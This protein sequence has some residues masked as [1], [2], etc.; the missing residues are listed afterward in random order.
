MQ[1][2][3]QTGEGIVSYSINDLTPLEMHELCVMR[4]RIYQVIESHQKNS[5]K[6]EY[7]SDD[8]LITL[9]SILSTLTQGCSSLEESAFS[10]HRREIVDALKDL[11]SSSFPKDDD[12]FGGETV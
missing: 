11:K 12:L 5:K 4:K 9:V 1:I 7:L 8:E 3:K 10:K 2:N 6:K